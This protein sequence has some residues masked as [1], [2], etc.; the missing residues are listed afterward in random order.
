MH[1]ELY[2]NKLFNLEEMDKF[3]VTLKLPDLTHVEYVNR[4]K[5]SEDIESLSQLLSGTESACQF[6]RHGFN[7]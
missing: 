4:P 3:L 2:T 6:R 7:C 5:T 1:Y